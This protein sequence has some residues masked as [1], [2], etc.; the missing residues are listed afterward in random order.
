MALLPGPYDAVQGEQTRR[1]NALLRKSPL[2]ALELHH[3]WVLR[4]VALLWGTPEMETFFLR[5]TTDFEFAGTTFNAR[6]L[7]ELSTLT[8]VH[9]MRQALIEQEQQ[10]A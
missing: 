4:R 1:L 8:Q 3:P 10:R 5:M 2:S 7:E 6:E 9:R